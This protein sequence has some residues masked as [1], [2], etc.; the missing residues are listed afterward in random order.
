MKSY[1]PTEKKLESILNR[2]RR[3]I[4]SLITELNN[5]SAVG[6][7]YKLLSLVK[8][9]FQI[10]EDRYEVITTE[11]KQ[12]L[13][14]ALQEGAKRILEENR[15]NHERN[16]Y[17]YYMN[18]EEHKKTRLDRLLNPPKETRVGFLDPKL[19]KYDYIPME[20]MKKNEEIILSNIEKVARQVFHSR[21]K[22]RDFEIQIHKSALFKLKKLYPKVRMTEQLYLLSSDKEIKEFY[23]IQ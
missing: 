10:T 11:G 20:A 3:N 13:I 14:L 23:R 2:K 5:L 22:N 12:Q 6:K 21:E 9:I 1:E 15:E 16:W 8:Q 18:E 17:F 7:K 19:R 4:E